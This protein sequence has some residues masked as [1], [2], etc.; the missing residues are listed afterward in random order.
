MKTTPTW[1]VPATVSVACLLF[2]A[3]ATTVAWP[4]TRHDGWFADM[5]VHGLG[6][7][8]TV[9][10]T[11]VWL[12]GPVRLGKLITFVG[13]TYYIQDLRAS[14]DVVVFAV[15]FCLAYLWYAGIA[16]LALA[17]PYGELPGRVDRRVVVVC[18]VASIGTQVIRFVVDQPHPPWGYGIPQVNTLCA[19]LGSVAQGAL[20]VVVILLVIRN[21][22]I[23]SRVRAGSPGRTGA[24]WCSSAV[25][26]SSAAR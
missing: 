6:A 12:R 25:S 20:A 1:L 10:G 9:L 4:V 14:D 16:H 13:G 21:W 3:V 8:L 19:R 24:G 15:G 23:S 17:L 11:A 26:W 18:Y 7:L 5:V 22:L 2:S